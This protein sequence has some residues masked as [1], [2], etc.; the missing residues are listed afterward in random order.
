MFPMQLKCFRI[1]FDITSNINCSR[2]VGKYSKV[3]S[4]IQWQ[5]YEKQSYATLQA[6][7]K[8]GTSLRFVFKSHLSPAKL[9]IAGGCGQDPKCHGTNSTFSLELWTCGYQTGNTPYH[10]IHL[11]WIW[12]GFSKEFAVWHKERGRGDVKHFAWRAQVL[13]H[14]CGSWPV[15]TTHVIMTCWNMAQEQERKLR[16]QGNHPKPCDYWE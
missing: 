6:W 4:S 10:A 13:Q 3:T 14:S 16:S 11:S 8:Y 9:F 1:H 2:H 5:I 15:N 7:D 12:S